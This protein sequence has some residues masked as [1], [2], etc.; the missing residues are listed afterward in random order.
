MHS[1]R[2]ARES[3]VDAPEFYSEMAMHL[4][5]Q[6]TTEA[7]VD[8]ITKYARVATECDDAG[9]LL[10]PA[11]QRL[12]TVSATSERVE[13]SHALQRELDEGPC[14]DAIDGYGVYLSPDVEIDPRW[15]RWGPKVADLG[16]HGV[17][18]VRLETKNRRYGSLNL[19]AER[20]GEF[21]EADLAL[22]QIF[23]RHA[24]IALATAHHEEGMQ[25]AIDVRKLIGQAQ[26][27]LMERFDVDAD[28]AFAVLRRY[29]QHHN[30]KI[31]DVAGWVVENRRAPIAD[32]GRVADAVLQ[33]DDAVP[34]D[35]SAA[36]APA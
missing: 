33:D 4:H 34:G 21:S 16:L 31:Q 25:V 5:E 28:S 29:S 36:S 6:E 11:R 20:R 18:S 22:A 14:L 30:M 8:L 1:I 2:M 7:T 24:S 26:G 10:S 32:L 12:E 35:D 3:D 17:M 9:I 13:I 19:Y 27:I 23:A 15:P